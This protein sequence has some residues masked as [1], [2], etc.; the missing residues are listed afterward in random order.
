MK[1]TELVALHELKMSPARL[2]MSA[3]KI[4]ALIGMEFEMY[5]PNTAQQDE[6]NTAL[7]P[8]YDHDFRPRSIEDIVDFYRRG[9]AGLSPN[10]VKSLTA[11][12]ETMYWDY[13]TKEME[14]DWKTEGFE[15]FKDFVDP[16]DIP[17]D[18][19]IEDVWEDY[20][21][22]GSRLRSAAYYAFEEGFRENPPSEASWLRDEGYSSMQDVNDALGYDWPYEKPEELDEPQSLESI[23]NDFEKAVGRYVRI[24]TTASNTAYGLVIDGSL[25][26]PNDPADGGL[27]FMSPPLPMEKIMSDLTKVRAW[28][29]KVGAYTN[30]T[31]GLHI[32]VSIPG[33]D[34]KKLD[35]VKLAIMMG[36]EW[37]SSQFDRLGSDYAQSAFRNV[38]RNAKDNPAVATALMQAMSGHLKD[39]AT[40]VIHDLSTAK[41]TSANMKINVN[42]INQRVEFRS[43]GND[44]LNTY[45]DKIPATVNRFVVALNS[46]LDPT[47]DLREYRTKL[48]KLLSKATASKDILNTFIMLSTGELKR[49]ELKSTLAKTKLERQVAKTTAADP[50][51]VEGSK[52]NFSVKVDG[53]SSTRTVTA[54]NVADAI[55]QTRELL[56]LDKMHYPDTDFHVTMASKVNPV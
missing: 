17:E 56:D 25:E 42:P 24:K 38:E 19:T 18:E 7:E 12:L 48:Y 37:V 5:V 13:V 45:Y 21:G 2:Q 51:S 16:A 33:L 31:C 53:F 28:A 50:T 40:H 11:K 41:Y 55:A 22:V 30:H 52:Y 23:A 43:P 20:R 34:M 44:W 15:F 46:A 27:E 47:A 6:N 54:A 14:N 3:S 36:D 9:D 32:N 26:E 10:Q 49:P 39:L 35:Y 4:P 1:I 29:K 8:D